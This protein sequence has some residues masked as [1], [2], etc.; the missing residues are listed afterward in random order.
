MDTVILLLFILT[1]RVATI[2]LSLVSVGQHFAHCCLINIWFERNLILF[3]YSSC[4][5]LPLIFPQLTFESSLY[6]CCIIFLGETK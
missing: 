4:F 1:D 6:E 3:L 5:L 2:L